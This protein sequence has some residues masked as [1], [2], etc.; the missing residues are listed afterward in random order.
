M[1]F[2]SKDHNEWYDSKYLDEFQGLFLRIMGKGVCIY[3][4]ILF[5]WVLT[6]ST[7]V[8]KIQQTTIRNSFL[9]FLRKKGFD[10]SC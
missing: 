4:N 10:M 1:E 8:K 2:V 5:I 7:A 3:D 9:I 6:L